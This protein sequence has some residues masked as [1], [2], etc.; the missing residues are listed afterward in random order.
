[1]K[2]LI[3]LFLFLQINI[4]GQIKN[5]TTDINVI[6]LDGDIALVINNDTL[7]TD[8]INIVHNLIKLECT[9][10]DTKWQIFYNMTEEKL[11]CM[12]YKLERGSWVFQYNSKNIVHKQFSR[13]ELLTSLDN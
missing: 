3:I 12:K 7:E 13:P 8:D 9:N 11:Y 2:Q 1:M 6:S 4:F 10:K 5:D